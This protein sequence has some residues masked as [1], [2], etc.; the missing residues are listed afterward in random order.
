MR[1]HFL[2]DSERT[3]SIFDV[4]NA[5]TFHTGRRKHILAVKHLH[6]LFQRHLRNNIADLLLVRQQSLSLQRHR[7]D[8]HEEC[9]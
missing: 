4:G 2:T 8:K 9:C 1:L 5:Q 6:F 3:V 7:D